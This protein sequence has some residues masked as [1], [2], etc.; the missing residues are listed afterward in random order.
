LG[1]REIEGGAI[2]MVKKL[3]L[4]SSIEEVSLVLLEKFHFLKQ[5]R[6]SRYYSPINR[7]KASLKKCEANINRVVD[8]FFTKNPAYLK[9][10]INKHILINH[11]MKIVKESEIY[12]PKC[13]IDEKST[14]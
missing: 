7:D 14:M 12:C 1:H 11:M 5:C 8:V 6:H 4:A 10:M 13:Q 9:R 2:L 3:T